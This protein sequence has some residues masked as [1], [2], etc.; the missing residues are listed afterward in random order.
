M[1]PCCDSEMDLVKK[2]FRYFFLP[3]VVSCHTIGFHVLN[4]AFRRKK[5]SFVDPDPCLFI[6]SFFS[7]FLQWHHF[8][9]M[10]DLNL[11]RCLTQN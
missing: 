3:R 8:F 2:G 4:F 10:K 6:G 1:V 11:H 7:T 9:N 5:L